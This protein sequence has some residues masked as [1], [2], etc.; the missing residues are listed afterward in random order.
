MNTDKKNLNGLLDIRFASI[1]F[2]FRLAGIP[3]KLKNIST[4][5]IVYMIIVIICSCSMFMG[6]FFD[7][8]VHRDDL[9]RA[10]TTMPA[11]ISFAN[12][13]WIFSNCR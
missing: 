10:M 2:L 6:M 4:T 9:G 7:V 13:M 3:V 12:Y 1:I 5:Y 8:Y 11:L